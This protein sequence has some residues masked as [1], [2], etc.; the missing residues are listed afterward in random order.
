MAASNGVPQDSQGRQYSVDRLRKSYPIFIDTN[1]A[2]L[3]FDNPAE[4]AGSKLNGFLL[5]DRQTTLQ[6][7]FKKLADIVKAKE[8]VKY[9]VGPLGQKFQ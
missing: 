6:V 8:N 5:E 7:D 4:N 3:S 1:I 2:V 9:R